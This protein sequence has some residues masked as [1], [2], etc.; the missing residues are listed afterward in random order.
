MKL[1][2]INKEQHFTEPPPRFNEAS[3]IKRLEE[4]GIGRPSTYA[5]IIS[6]IQERNYVKKRKTGL[7]QD[8][9][10]LLNFFLEAYFQQIH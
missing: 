7:F 3:L 1:E 8:T 10:R 6:K 2:K 9:G 4:E 5:S